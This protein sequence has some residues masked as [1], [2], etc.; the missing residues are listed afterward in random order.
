MLIPYPHWLNPGDNGWQLTAATLVGLMSL[1][2][3]AVL[4]GGI[5]KRKWAVNTML[6][7]FAGFAGVLIVWVLWAY[8]MSFGHPFNLWHGVLSPFIGLPGSILSHAYEEGQASIPLLKG[9]MPALHFPTSSLA[10]FQFV[11][12]AITPLLFLGSVLGRMSFKAWCIF[13]P[14]WTTCAYTVNAM[15]LWGGGYWA[16][17][18]ALDYSGGYVIHLAAGVSG[19]VAAWVIGP[20]LAKDRRAFPPT[21]LML[22]AVGAGM[23]WLG[24]NGFNGGDSYFA[25]ANAGAAVLNTNLCTATA[26]LVWLLIDMHFGPKKPNFLGAVNGMIVGL[27]AITPAAGYVNGWGA[28]CIGAIASS[29]VWFA[30]NELSR[31]RPFSKVDD[32]LGVV[33]THGFAG[34]FGGLLTG[35]FADPKMVVYLSANGKSSGVAGAFYGHPGLI[36]VQFLAALTI[37]VW[38][39]AVT[40]ILL[41]LIGLVIPLRMKESELSI[42]D[43]AVHGEYVDL[44]VD[45]ERL[46]QMISDGRGISLTGESLP[47]SAG[48]VGAPEEPRSINGDNGNGHGN[49]DGNGSG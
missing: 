20:R 35:V 18:G 27:V 32:A 9:V 38:D 17:R 30:F 26:L 29:L 47:V 21:N 23:L 45:D 10:Y 2:G 42:G 44:S 14:A 48:G 4:Y 41:K 11:F 39:G 19:F 8:E 15:L 24:W 43:L 37:I 7:A 22:V 28:L 33:Y 49:G 13:V 12:A 40:F 46:L 16:A 36:W 3:I 1:P 5:V 25:G 6:M 34:L 31:H